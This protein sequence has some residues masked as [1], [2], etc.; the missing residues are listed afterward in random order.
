MV[1]T[2]LRLRFR[3]L[4]NQLSRSPWQL[5]GF[6]FGALYGLGV[7]TAALVG[8]VFLGLGPE[9][10]AATVITGVGSLVTV[11]WVL[12]PLL[13]FGVDTTLDP[14]RL[15][16]FPMS[17]RRMMVALALAGVCGIPGIVTAIAALGTLATWVHWPAALI[18]SIVCI[19][20][21]VF[22]AV[23]ASRTMASLASGTGGNRRVR[24]ASGILV[25]IPLILA[26]PIVAGIATGF[27]MNIDAVATTVQVLGW[28]PIGAAWSV[29]GEVASG[30]GLAAVLKLAIAAATLAL[31][32]V[33]WGWSMRNSLAH[34]RQQAAARVAAGKI[35]W[36]GRVPANATGALFARSLTYWI[37]DPRYLRQL[38]TVPIVP[39]LIWFYARNGN[40]A[41][42]LSFTGPVVAL[43]VGII[44]YA[45]L[46]YDGTAYG[47]ELATGASGRADRLGRTL[48]AAVTGLP[49]VLLGTVLP[50]FWSQRWD[51]FP[52]VLGMGLG[53][54][55]TSY[56]VCAV[57]SAQ[58]VIPVAASG[59]NPFK[60]VPGTTF[61]QGMSFLLIWLI[62]I[63]LS[64]PAII[65]GMIAFF[66]GNTVLSLIVLAVGVV[67]GG[68]FLVVGVV[69]GGRML[70]RTGPVLLARLK[71]MKN[72]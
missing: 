57:T 39:V 21:G 72:S 14:D 3:V 1:A 61:L 6:I 50:F 52:G 26:G 12:G 5:V 4:G 8:L 28:T 56:G 29:P 49:L 34:P 36:F 23:V 11:G 53:I 68:V 62:A 2:L 42:A 51:V 32:W 66:T 63:G 22:T 54:L 46:S 30:N 7:L 20:L 67:L 41:E 18:A 35:G 55:L 33:L 44:L 60:R 43:F 19:P 47:T 45:D 13:A 70:D 16:V 40:V 24:E 38:I 65:V 58:L 71:A 48:A 31:L 10:V 64:S 69:V 27:R 9:V 59:D 17:L 25:F 15:I 37:R